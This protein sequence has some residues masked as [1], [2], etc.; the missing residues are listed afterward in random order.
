M[1]G[2]VLSSAKV[3]LDFKEG[4]KLVSLVQSSWY[5]GLPAQT[6][7]REEQWA[8]PNKGLGNNNIR[9]DWVHNHENS[10]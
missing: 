10:S 7:N 8:S 9:E 6:R 1:T 5:L 4:A 2:V 3:T